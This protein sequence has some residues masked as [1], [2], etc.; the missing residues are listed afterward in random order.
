[1]QKLFENWRRFAEDKGYNPDTDYSAVGPDDDMLPAPPEPA[2]RRVKIKPVV[3]VLDRFNIDASAYAMIMNKFD[4]PQRSTA[5]YVK[6]FPMI[7]VRA[8]EHIRD[9]VQLL[10]KQRDIGIMRDNITFVY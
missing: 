2:G 9:V 1:M 5:E 4:R 8:K 6:E 10:L 7:D 3:K